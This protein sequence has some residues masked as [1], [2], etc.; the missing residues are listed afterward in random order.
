MEQK[1]YIDA[2]VSDRELRHAGC[3]QTALMRSETLH[4]AYKLPLHLAYKL[5]IAKKKF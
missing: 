3:W 2:H 1:C 4:L 5:H